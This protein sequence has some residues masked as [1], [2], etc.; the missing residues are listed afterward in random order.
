MAITTVAE[1]KQLMQITTSADDALI[2]AA[3]DNATAIIEQNATSMLFTSQ[4]MTEYYSGGGR[5]TLVLRSR[6]VTS[7]SSLYYD[8]T[9]YFGAAT[10]FGASSLL[11]SGVDYVLELSQPGLSMSGIVHRIG[12]IWGKSRVRVGSDLVGYMEPGL[13]NIKIT[14]TAGYDGVNFQIPSNIKLLNNLLARQII[15]VAPTAGSPISS[16][17]FEYY[18][19]SLKQESPADFATIA[20]LMGAIQEYTF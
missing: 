11:T 1:Y 5:S 12:G 14:Y 4:T 9:G 10:G 13:G 7:I 19:Y 20:S 2:A 16:E 3:L 18:S 6:P 8:D 17:S 15:R